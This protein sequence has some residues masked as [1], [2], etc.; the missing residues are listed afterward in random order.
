MKYQANSWN[1]TLSGST[2]IDGLPWSPLRSYNLSATGLEW[3]KR[4][5]HDS[6]VGRG[7]RL[8]VVIQDRAM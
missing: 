6:V 5:Y 7:I 1:D 4:E 2:L 8:E 3:D